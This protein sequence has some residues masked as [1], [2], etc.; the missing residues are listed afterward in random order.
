MDGERRRRIT[1]EGGV[2]LQLLHE[3]VEGVGLGVRQYCHSQSQGV[4]TVMRQACVGEELRVD[5]L[6]HQASGLKGALDHQQIRQN[7]AL[8]GAREQLDR[9]QSA[10]QSRATLLPSIFGP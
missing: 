6:Q 8:A 7:D 9:G 10:Q 1:R 2:S 3:R 4:E 5:M